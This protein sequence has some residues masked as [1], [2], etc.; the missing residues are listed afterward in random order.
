[1]LLPVLSFHFEH[2][3]AVIIVYGSLEAL[4]MQFSVDDGSRSPVCVM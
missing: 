4:I 1:M 3:W 2:V